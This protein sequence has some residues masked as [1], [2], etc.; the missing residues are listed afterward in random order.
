MA[1]WCPPVWQERE[2]FA[3]FTSYTTCGE[4]EETEE[5]KG[6]AW[7]VLRVG[8]SSAPHHQDPA[9]SPALQHCGLCR[10]PRENATMP[11]L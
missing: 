3:N 11:C 1:A 2:L 5:G 8:F 7:G 9:L 4:W 6:D 10:F